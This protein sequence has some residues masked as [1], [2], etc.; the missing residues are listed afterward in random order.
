VKGVSPQINA[1]KASKLSLSSRRVMR[2]T[3]SHALSGVIVRV[4]QRR[5]GSSKLGSRCGRAGAVRVLLSF[6]ISISF[7]SHTGVEGLSKIRGLGKSSPICTLIGL[8]IER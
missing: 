6:R 1:I 7:K 5:I 4:D 8:T 2:S 3:N